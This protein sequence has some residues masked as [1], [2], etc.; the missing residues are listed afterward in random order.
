MGLYDR[1]YYRTPPRGGV[2]KLRVWSVTTWLIIVN[3]SIFVLD[4]LLK[5]AFARHYTPDFAHRLQIPFTDIRT[6]RGPLEVFGWYS[7]DTAIMHAQAWRV[8]TCQFLHT[9]LLHLAMNMLGLW[10]FGELVERRLGRRRYL[11]YYLLCGIAGPVMY[12]G[13][14]LVGLLTPATATPLIGAS[15]GIFGIM[16][17]AAYL[18]PDRLLYV[19]FF[20][21]PLKY[22]AWFM[23][24]LA[25]WAVV[26][27]GDNAGGQAAHLG[28]ALLGYVLIRNDS[29]LNLVA[30]RNNW[31]RRKKQTKDWSRDMNR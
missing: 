27:H 26:M 14:W 30:K 20:E 24:A 19:Y 12:T 1:D 22:F 28:G 17:A 11:F 3:I 16:L 2:G 25:A 21:V 29:A 10:I 15:A 31:G 6:L 23:V 5:P 13:L 7:I 8:V 4:A 9:G 18:E